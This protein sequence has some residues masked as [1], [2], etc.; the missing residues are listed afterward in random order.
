MEKIEIISK[1]DRKS[2]PSLVQ[3]A[4][5]S[6]PRPL[7]V[8]LHTWSYTCMENYSGYSEVCRN[9]NWHMIFPNF[10]GP[11]NTPDGC[12]SDLALSDIEDAVAYMCENYPVDREKIYLVGGSG[13]GHFALLVAGRR[14]D[15]FTAVSAWC[16]ISDIA[17]WH[18]ESKVRENCYSQHI[19]SAC[20]GDPDCD[21]GALREAQLRSPLSWL[22]NAANKVPVD[23]STGIHDGHTGSVPVGHAI[24][25]F[26]ILAAE[27][28]RISEEDIASIEASEKVPAHLAAEES[29]PAYGSHTVY[30]RK[31]SRL[32]RLTLFEGGH[33]IFP[34][35]AGAWLAR[36][37]RG[38]TP[39]FAN[40]EA[41][42]EQMLNLSN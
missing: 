2:Q 20:G 32:S 7:L 18:R 42:E 24:R 25:A 40:G 30:L 6:E 21:A 34:A 15:L 4:E 1:V 28:D 38:G 23:I 31:I 12:G 27:G 22:A 9:R 33:N 19:E 29:D 41:M 14:P 5:G 10:R 16:P 37:R 36:Q 39:D 11:N 26:N 8:A 13:G 17:R 3:A 35:I